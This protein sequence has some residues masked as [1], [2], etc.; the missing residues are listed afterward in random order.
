MAKQLLSGQNT[1]TWQGFIVTH[2]HCAYCAWNTEI[3]LW[4][5]VQSRACTESVI[6]IS[7]PPVPLLQDAQINDVTNTAAANE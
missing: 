2:V 6:L 7:H 4:M 5:V 1:F 3:L